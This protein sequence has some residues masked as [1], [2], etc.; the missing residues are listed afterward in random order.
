VADLLPVLL[1]IA[2]GLSLTLV[3][4]ALWHSL[5]GLLA[6]VH[7]S[8]AR[9]PAA[10]AARAALVHEKEELLA[11]IRELRFEHELGKVS[12]ADFERL[13]QRYRAR[14]RDVLRELDQQVEPYRARARALIEQAIAG[15]DAPPARGEQ[16]PGATTPAV[17]ASG[18]DATAAASPV[19]GVAP[20]KGASAACVKCGSGNDADALFCKKCGQRMREEARA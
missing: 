18:N 7:D 6:H 12:Q 3:L 17:D 4:F 10:S 5:R 14:A 13:E 2:V 1:V 11:A 15:A 9:V 16:S 20:A 8:A 19:A